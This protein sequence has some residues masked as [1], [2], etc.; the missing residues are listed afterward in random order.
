MQEIGERTKGTWEEKDEDV[1]TWGRRRGR[2]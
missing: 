1:W 2:R